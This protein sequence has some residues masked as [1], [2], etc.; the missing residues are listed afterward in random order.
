MRVLRATAALF[1]LHSNLQGAQLLRTGVQRARP[2]ITRISSGGSAS[3]EIGRLSIKDFGAILKD[4]NI[5]SKYQV[6]DVREP[7][8]LDMA[9][10]SFKDVMNLPMGAS[11]EWG[12]KVAN[13]GLLDPLKPTICMVSVIPPNSLAFFY[14]DHFKIS[15]QNI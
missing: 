7:H 9:K 12:T 15:I 10:L 5:R 11:G 8:E 1:V 2:Q 13:G 3:V 14:I 6:I 4:E